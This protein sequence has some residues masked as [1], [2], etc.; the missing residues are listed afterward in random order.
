MSRSQGRGQDPSE[1]DE[2]AFKELLRAR[3]GGRGV[4]VTLKRDGRP[5][6]SNVGYSYDPATETIRVATT[7]DRAKTRNVRRDARVSFHVTTEDMF[8]YGVFEGTASVSA[9]ACDPYDATVDELVEMYRATQ[10][11]H[12][13]WEE[14]RETKVKDRRLVLRVKVARAYGFVFQR[15]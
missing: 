2:D 3:S 15:S 1:S 6:L 7:A 4:L 10:G 12:P 8:S 5:Q 13:D 14:F 11:E 9:V